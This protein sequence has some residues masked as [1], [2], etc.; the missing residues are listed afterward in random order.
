MIGSS[1]DVVSFQ[2]LCQLLHLLTRQTVDDTALAS[3]L[4]DELDDILVHIHRF[5]TYLI[6]QVRTVER[7]LE[8]YGIQ[9]TQILLDIRTY[10]ICSRSRQCDNRSL[11]YLIDDRTDATILWSEVMTPLRDTVRLINGI[12]R[13]LCLFQELYI[14]LFGQR[15]RSDIQQLSTSRH[16]ICLDLVNGRLVQ[17]RVQIVRRSLVTHRTDDIHLILHQGYQR[18]D[19]DSGTV[20]Q[21]RRQLVTQRL[22]TTC[23]HQHESIPAIEHILHDG[24]LITFELVKAEILLQR[25]CQVLF[26]FCHRLQSIIIAGATGRAASGHTL[27]TPQRILSF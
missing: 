24:L 21:Q 17:R 1:L 11:S 26:F 19:D 6:V 4:L 9:D 27:S 16:N 8:L 10:L 13:Y 20:H 3:V 14:I 12:E 23:R 25:L 18:R 2:N 5:G 15:L 22:T 7:A